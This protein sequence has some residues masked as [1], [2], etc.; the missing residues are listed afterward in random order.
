MN[1]EHVLCYNY[2]TH[3]ESTQHVRT[4]RHR[5]ILFKN[6]S[7]MLCSYASAAFCPVC[8]K[9]ANKASTNMCQSL[10]LCP[11]NYAIWLPLHS[12]LCQQKSPRA[13]HTT[14]LRV[15]CFKQVSCMRHF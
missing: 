15:A 1:T 9:Q 13:T 14:S 10:K 5:Q 12:K 6:Q 3:T 4:L 8:E 2:H 7:I 11:V